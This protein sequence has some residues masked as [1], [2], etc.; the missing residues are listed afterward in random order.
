MLAWLID[1]VPLWVVIC[2][3]VAG[4]GLFVHL[5]QRIEMLEDCA[6]LQNGAPD[7]TK[8]APQD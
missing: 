3:G 4:A 1:P 7:P 8:L 5:R 2:L 6:K